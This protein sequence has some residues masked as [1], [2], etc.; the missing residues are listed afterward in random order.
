MLI[1]ESV[2]FC[3]GADIRRVNAHTRLTREI[4][5]SYYEVNTLI[6]GGRSHVGFGVYSWSI[7]GRDFH[8]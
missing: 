5:N 4:H 7:V 2:T 1:G 8:R 6:K 3:V